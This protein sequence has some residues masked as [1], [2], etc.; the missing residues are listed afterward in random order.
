M[1][2]LAL[3]AALLVLA[4][5][6]APAQEAADAD[7][8]DTASVS[9]A[10]PDGTFTLELNNA[11]S[12]D[13]EVC[14]LTYVATN[15]SAED[16]AQASFQVGFFDAE[17]IVRRILVLDFGALPPGKTRIVPFNLPEQSCEDLSRIVV[18][19]VAECAVAGGGTSAICG[20]G[21]N[22]ASRTDIQFGL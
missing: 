6:L 21:L 14:Q 8:P 4:P 7:A 9:P 2:R 3:L 11:A 18:N 10:L 22:T 16:L 20:A 17:G 12:L 1:T 13:G 5:G 19:D 15:D